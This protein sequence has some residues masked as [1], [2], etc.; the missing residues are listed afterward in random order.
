MAEKRKAESSTL[1]PPS[2]Y[3]KKEEDQESESGRGVEIKGGDGRADGDLAVVRSKVALAFV[4]RVWTQVKDFKSYSSCM[5]RFI[6]SAQ[7]RVSVDRLP[8][9]F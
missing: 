2:K 7:S 8:D 9:Q 3:I 5:L 1:T 6:D 4:D